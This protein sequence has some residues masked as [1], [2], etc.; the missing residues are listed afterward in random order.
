MQVLL[1][2]YK[3]LPPAVCRPS[4]APQHS[5]GAKSVRDAAAFAQSNHAAPFLLC[6]D[7]QALLSKIAGQLLDQDQTLS[8][9]KITVFESLQAVH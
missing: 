3:R 7:T 2:R 9:V 1:S 8:V 5:S 6:L 4:P